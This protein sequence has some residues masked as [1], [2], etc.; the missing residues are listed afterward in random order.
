MSINIR[1]QQLKSKNKNWYYQFQ[2]GRTVTRF[3]TKYEACEYN[4]WNKK[5]QVNMRD[6]EKRNIPEWKKS[7]T[8]MHIN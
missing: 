6:V 3:K 4:I 8:T 1:S 5:F 7:C 2:L